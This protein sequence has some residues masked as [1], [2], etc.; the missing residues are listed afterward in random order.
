VYRRSA[1][2]IQRT[3]PPDTLPL[4]FHAAEV[5]RGLSAMVLVFPYSYLVSRYTLSFTRFSKLV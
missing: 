2:R 3:I 4:C 5:D 1:R